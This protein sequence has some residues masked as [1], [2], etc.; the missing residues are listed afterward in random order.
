MTEAI[1]K[2]DLSSSYLSAVC[3]Y[4][5]IDYEKVHHDADSTDAEIK[6]VIDL[7][8]GRKYTSILRVQLK[9]TSAPSQYK[10]KGETLV[11]KL[12][13]KNYNDLC[14]EG[15]SEII[16]ALLVL[17]EKESEWLTWTREELLIKGCMY[18]ASFVSQELSENSGTVSVHINKN[19]VINST[20]LNIIMDKIAREE[21]PCSIQ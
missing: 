16:L 5:G 6:K 11:Y 14:R 2:E 8:N 15:T 19:N 1:R 9:S 4:G 17:P 18:W 7:E 20:T 10:D 13:A 3:A 21:W 12:N